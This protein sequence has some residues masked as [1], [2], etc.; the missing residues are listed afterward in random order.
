M[1]VCKRGRSLVIMF[2]LSENSLSTD[3]LVAD[4]DR[5]RLG[6]LANV[7]YEHLLFFQEVNIFIFVSIL[8][9]SSIYLSNSVLV[10]ASSSNLS[11]DVGKSN[12]SFNDDTN[13][14]LL[15]C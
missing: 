8:L 15:C 1:L 7:G 4:I 6:M 13:R 12:I 9:S 10:T 3:V 5:T 14:R 2:P 11:N